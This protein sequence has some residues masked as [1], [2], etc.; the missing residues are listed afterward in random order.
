MVSLIRAIDPRLLRQ[1][2]E[3]VT[4]DFE[5]LEAKADRTADERLLLK[6]R[7]ALD[8]REE[9]ILYALEMTGA[10]GRRL[11]ER[12]SGLEKLQPWADDVLAMSRSLRARLPMPA[13]TRILDI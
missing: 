5:S 2:P 9:T 11:A 3:G 10:E 12:L 6:L 13:D 1:G 7:G 8:T 4:V